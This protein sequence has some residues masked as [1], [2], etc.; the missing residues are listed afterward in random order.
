MID[1][2]RLKEVR[3]DKWCKSCRH[4][5]NRFAVRDV[6]GEFQY[7]CCDCLEPVNGVRELSEKPIYW[8]EA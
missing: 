7:P 4:Y 1:E 3:Y 2:S 5:N 6:S 8:E